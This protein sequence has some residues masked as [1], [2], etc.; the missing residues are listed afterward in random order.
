MV[1]EVITT[2]TLTILFHPDY[3]V[4]FGITPNLLTLQ[5]KTYKRSRAFCL[6]QIYRRWGVSPRPEDADKVIVSVLFVKEWR[7]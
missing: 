5:D 1:T 3:T 7:Y 2:A 4:G 6:K